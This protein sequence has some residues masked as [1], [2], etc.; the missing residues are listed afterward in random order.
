MFFASLRHH[1]RSAKLANMTRLFFLALFLAGLFLP[2]ASVRAQETDYWL[3]YLN[4]LMNSRF[5]G[6]NL[7]AHGLDPAGWVHIASATCLGPWQ[8]RTIATLIEDVGPVRGVLWDQS[9]DCDVSPIPEV[10]EFYAA[11]PEIRP[12]PEQA[13][14]APLIADPRQPRFSMSYQRYRISGERFD[15]ASVAFGEYFGLAS[16]FFGRAGSAQL[17]LQ[18]AVFAL[19]NLDQESKDLINADYWVGLPLSFRRGRWSYLLRVYHQSSHLGDEFL[20]GNPDITRINLSYED[21]E[22]I[23]SHEWQRM[24]LYTGVGHLISSEPELDP[25]HARVGAEFIQP[26]LVHKLDFV[27][28]V[29]VQSSEELDWALSRSYQAGLEFRNVSD[30]RVRLMAEYFV[31]HSPHGQ[32]FREHLRYVGLGLYFGF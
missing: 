14:F 1:R 20:L 15:A 32:F 22:L 11:L 31:G 2:L 28:G 29:D 25:W 10:S 3:G 7:R 19:F 4:A 9:P 30:R 5:P 8:Q 18:G 24:R 26:R 21:A 27:A 17:A 13:L 6:L 16:R 12:L 23:A